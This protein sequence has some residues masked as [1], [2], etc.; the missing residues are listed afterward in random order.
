MDQA[1]IVLPGHPHDHEVFRH[2][3][4]PFAEGRFP[5]SL[6]AVVQCTVLEGREPA[7]EVV[8]TAENSWIVGDGFNDP[9]LPNAAVVSCMRLVVEQNSTVARLADL[10]LGHLAYRENPGMPWVVEPH[11]WPEE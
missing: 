9:N 10:P 7:R 2:L 1:N 11:S 3:P 5:D 6:G 8:H 4:F